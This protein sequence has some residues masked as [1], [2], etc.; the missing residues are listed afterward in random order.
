MNIRQAVPKDAG[1]IA[2][3]WNREISEGVSTFNS[4]EKS[5]A[6]VARMIAERGAAVLVAEDDRHLIGFATY[7]SFR[8][9][10]GYA[11]SMEH[12]IYLDPAARGRGAGRALMRAIE[13]VARDDGVH[14]LIAGIGGENAA[15]I[16]FH[17]ALGFEE[18]GRMPE[19]GRKFGRWM[20]LVLMQKIL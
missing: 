3:I 4:V 7:G 20:D 2:A 18:V 11:Q 9:G 17:S 19:V 6:E 16:A 15:G 13:Q 14:V 12:T 5:D 8:G 1:A 10:I